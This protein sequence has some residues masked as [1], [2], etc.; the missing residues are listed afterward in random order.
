MRAEGRTAAGKDPAPKMFNSVTIDK[1][2]EQ[3]AR[4]FIKKGLPFDLADDP[5]FRQALAMTAKLGGQY[6]V[7]SQD[8]MTKEPKF[9]CMLPHRTLMSGKLLSKVNAD[10]DKKIRQRVEAMGNTVGL[11]LISHGWTGVQ[12]KPIMNAIACCPIGR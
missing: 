5:Q 8:P 9:D 4:A 10:L 11:M 3:W 7:I 12:R 6:V 2:N 1:V